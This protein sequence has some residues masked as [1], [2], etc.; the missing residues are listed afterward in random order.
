MTL[1]G[2]KFKAHYLFLSDLNI[3]PSVSHL[4][5]RRNFS[6]IVH[7]LVMSSPPLGHSINIPVPGSPGKPYSQYIAEKGNFAGMLLGAIFYGIV[8]ALFFHCVDTLLKPLNRVRRGAKWGLIAYTIVI[9]SLATIGTAMNLDVQSLSYID[10]RFFP[11]TDSSLPSGPLAYQASIDSSIL[12]IVP[13]ITFLVNNLLSAGFLLYR[14]H[15]IYSKSYH[16][17]ALPILIYTAS[18]TVSMILVYFKALQ[19]NN[20]TWNSLVVDLD[21]PY[22]AVT[23]SLNVVLTLMII[24]RLILYSKEIQKVLV[25]S[26]CGF[27][28]IF[29]TVL[30][31]SSA[32]YAVTFI[33]FVVPWSAGNWVADIFFPILRETQVISPLL[34]VL[35]TANQSALTGD[36]IVFGTD[37]SPQSTDPEKSIIGDAPLRGF[38]YPMSSRGTHR[39]SHRSVSILV[40]T[41]VDFHHDRT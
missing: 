40:E 11:G 4:F 28:K 41:T 20:S 37:G 31:E 13:R 39:Q 16:A 15:V 25:P 6:R 30:V 17:I 38:E 33:L 21:T 5:L 24:T 14:C 19:R 10:N 3:L 27:C 18:L 9:F 8:A 26:S 34:I 35:R 23:L 22:Y 29:T 36:T 2:S 12:D 1:P 7:V 32:L